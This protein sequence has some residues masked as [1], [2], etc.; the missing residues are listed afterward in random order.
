MSEWNRAA[1]KSGGNRPFKIPVG[2][3]VGMLEGTACDLCGSVGT[4][5]I[6]P[7]MEPR[8]LSCGAIQKVTR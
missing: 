1:R 6:V 2:F 7:G 4:I 5:A 8:C 3:T